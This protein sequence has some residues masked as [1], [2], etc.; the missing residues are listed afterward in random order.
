MMMMMGTIVKKGLK[1]T[2][3]QSKQFHDYRMTDPEKL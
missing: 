2:I 1:A 3:I